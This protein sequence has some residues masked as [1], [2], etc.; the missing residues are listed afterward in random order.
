MVLG[1]RT[2]LGRRG[3]ATVA[4]LGG[5]WCCKLRLMACCSSSLST[6]WGSSVGD[7]GECGGSELVAA[8]AIEA[9]VAP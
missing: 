1:M 4:G 5:G 9:V 2:V 7:G 8:A 6:M 3:V